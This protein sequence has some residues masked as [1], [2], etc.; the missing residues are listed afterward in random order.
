MDSKELKLK[1]LQEIISCEDRVLLEK[2]EHLLRE[3]SSE[4]KEEG[5]QYSATKEIENTSSQLS[6]QQKEEL[7][8]RYKEYEQKGGELFSWEE[9]KSYILTGNDS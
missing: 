9:V 1:L 8:R 3:N 4:V 5:E 6:E 7:E 2:I